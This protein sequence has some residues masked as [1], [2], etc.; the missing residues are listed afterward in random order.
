[1]PNMRLSISVVAACAAIATACSKSA[2]P[3]AATAY[4]VTVAPPNV[5]MRAVGDAVQLNV[6][7]DPAV[8][9][10]QWTW[11]SSDATTVSVDA[12]GLA[13][14]VKSPVAGIS[15]CATLKTDATVRG[16]ATVTTPGA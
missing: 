8:T 5:V 10:A 13:R 7:V 1:M 6:S 14:A 11:S 9:G 15:L 4:T 12:N 16:C 2:T 3:T